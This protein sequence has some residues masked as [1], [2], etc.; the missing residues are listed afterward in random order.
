M[1]IFITNIGVS[2]FASACRLHLLSNPSLANLEQPIPQALSQQQPA[3][4]AAATA[5]T[6]GDPPGVIMSIQNQPTPIIAPAKSRIE[7][8]ERISLFWTIFVL[9]RYAALI[10]G[11]NT[12][13]RDE[14]VWTSWPRDADEWGLVSFPLC[15]PRLSS[16]IST[17]RCFCFSF[18]WKK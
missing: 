13:I 4:V 1:H 15:L 5:S 6:H 11:T 7:L 8:E 16:I 14:S 2:C 18:F 12:S 3:T 10:C 17:A 9:D